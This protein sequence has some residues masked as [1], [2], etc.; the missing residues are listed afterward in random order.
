MRESVIGVLRE[1][2]NPGLWIE[3]V[4]MGTFLTG[5]VALAALMSGA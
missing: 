3:L 2:A 4:S 1:A 5:I